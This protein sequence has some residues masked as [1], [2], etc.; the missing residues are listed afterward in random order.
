M[1]QISSTVSR[2]TD[3]INKIRNKLP[4]DALLIL[5]D[6]MVLSHLTYCCMVWGSTYHSNLETILKLQKKSLRIITKS[7]YRAH[8]EPLFYKLRKLNIFDICKLQ[9]AV[10]VFNSF[11]CLSAA[12]MSYSSFKFKIVQKQY[13]TRNEMTCSSILQ[14]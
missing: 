6:S 10:F 3:I 8:S 12:Q 11:H 7:S 4:S 5:Y 14:N 1:S 2:N 9:T 13:D